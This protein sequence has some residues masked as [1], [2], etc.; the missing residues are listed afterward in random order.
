MTHHAQKLTL[1][2]A[3]FT[4]ASEAHKAAD[5]MAEHAKALDLALELE[6]AEC[7]IEFAD[8]A[9]KA[10]RAFEARR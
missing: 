10:M 8:V 6:A 4:A 7:G 2:A 9:R 1:L 5:A 3:K